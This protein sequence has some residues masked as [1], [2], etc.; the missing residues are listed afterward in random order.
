MYLFVRPF[1]LNGNNVHDFVGIFGHMRLSARL[2]SGSFTMLFIFSRI[3]KPRFG[4]ELESSFPR[5]IVCFTATSVVYF[6]ELVNIFFHD[7]FRGSFNKVD[8]CNYK[9]KAKRS[10]IAILLRDIRAWCHVF[11]KWH[12]EKARRLLLDFEIVLLLD[13]IIFGYSL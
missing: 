13:W 4:P 1:L 3:W 6:K 8:T 12:T 5:I 10:L 9:R 7:A 11:V 2:L